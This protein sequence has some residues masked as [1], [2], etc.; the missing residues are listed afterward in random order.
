[1][2]RF[3]A[4]CGRIRWNGSDG[5]CGFLGVFLIRF[6]LFPEGGGLDDLH[7]K[8]RSWLLH[9]GIFQVR[10]ILLGFERVTGSG[11][12]WGFGECF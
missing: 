5:Q 2:R 10:R 1:M 8:G 11:W 12:E 9:V 7:G 4:G 3:R 6:C